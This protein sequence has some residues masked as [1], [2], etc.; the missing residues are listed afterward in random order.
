MTPTSRLWR[1]APAFFVLAALSLHAAPDW[2]ERIAKVPTPSYVGAASAVVLHDETVMD[3]KPDGV[4]TTTR[5]FAVRI[6]AATGR[7]YAGYRFNYVQKRDKVRSTGAWLLRN[8]KEVTNRDALGWIDHALDL[9]SALFGDNRGKTISRS[10]EAV[11]GDVFAVETVIDERLIVSEELRRFGHSLPTLLERFELRVPPGF[12]LTTVIRGDAARL[13]EHELPK[14]GHAWEWRD[15]PYVAAESNM[16]SIDPDRPLVFI[17]INPPA[18]AARYGPLVLG[19][20]NAQAKWIDRLNQDQCDTSAALREKALSLTADC[21]DN[22]SRIRAIGGY[23]QRFR[24]LQKND[25][26]GLGYG[27][28]AHKASQVFVEGHGDCKDKANLMLAM[29]REVGLE[30]YLATARSGD[31]HEVHPD[32]PT[33]MQFDHAIA[34]IKVSDDI[35][36]PAVV[37]TPRYGRVLFFDPTDLFTQPGDLPAH[38]QGTRVFIQ[39]ASNHELTELPRIPAE[40]GH[41]TIRK[42]SLALEGNGACVG[43]MQMEGFA[44]AGAF[45]RA[46]LF[47]R[48]TEEKLREFISGRF[49]ES[50]KSAYVSG[51]ERLDDPAGNKCGVKWTVAKAGYLQFLPGGAAIAPLLV[52]ERS[53]L[54]LLTQ[55]Q[56]KYPVKWPAVALDD[57]IELALPEGFGVEE[58]P[59]ALEF[60]SEYGR[61]L[62][63]VENTEGKITM[64]RQITLHPQLIPVA[65][66]AKVKKFLAD[67]TKA[68]RAALMLKR[69]G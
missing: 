25:N 50:L 61:Y 38:L 49:A 6:L 40:V 32:L 44:Q 26:L 5:R 9:S 51:L 37:E 28:Q 60:S 66:Y 31:D 24:Y 17:R 23:V 22:Y 53:G 55:A 65:D 39:T 35:E 43:T 41:L 18:N 1:L 54:P 15:Q 14:G 11:A 64:R 58:A 67:V 34:A 10:S 2:A 7:D 68:D 20:W 30:G 16:P 63:T 36:A 57:T 46:Q 21:S 29:L 3:L 56:R 4:A 27:Y 19:D 45:I 62:R 33:P 12:S 52:F 13:Q 48:S 47:N 59:T 69:Q 8:G 42:A